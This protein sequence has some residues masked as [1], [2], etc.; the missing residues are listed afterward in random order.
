[1][2][3]SLMCPSGTFAVSQNDH[4]APAILREDHNAE[5]KRL[6]GY[7]SPYTPRR[8][9]IPGVTPQRCQI[10]YA[11]TLSR[12]GSRFPSASAGAKLRAVIKKI[13]TRP[14][15]LVGPYQ[16][17][18]RYHYALGA[19]AITAYGEREMQDAGAYF[20]H[21]YCRR[22]ACPVFPQ[23]HAL[24]VDRIMESAHSFAQG[25]RRACPATGKEAPLTTA[26][27][28]APL[29]W[30]KDADET[31]QSKWLP[32]VV[33]R[34]NK[35]LGGGDLLG[36]EEVLGLM[37]MCPFSTAA[38][39]SGRVSLFCKLFTTDEWRQYS[40]AHSVGK[41]YRHG[42][43]ASIAE[44]TDYVAELAARLEGKPGQPRLR[45]EFTSMAYVPHRSSSLRV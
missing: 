40:H 3:Y 9:L 25:F 29:K 11:E 22:M 4:D 16:F 28:P 34:V 13:Q 41:F 15:H 30:P 26:P 32:P 24:H 42:R 1:M 10:T 37:D 45:A 38:S 12:H 33:E 21:T 23:L 35:D 18:R 17:L 39:A 20:C 27:K 6:W 2:C 44:A 7:F 43:F 36:P 8:S 31:W 19:D 5:I 14:A